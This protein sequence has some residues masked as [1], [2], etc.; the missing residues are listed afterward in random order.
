MRHCERSP[1]FRSLSTRKRKVE[2][3]DS[4]WEVRCIFFL[5]NFQEWK[6]VKKLRSF[7]SYTFFLSEI[8]FK[9]LTTVTFISV[10]ALIYIE[11]TISFLVWNT[12]SRN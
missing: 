10:L 3:Y 4:C 12:L 11:G 9:L 5:A 8:Y 2:Q 6:L 7:I 1:L